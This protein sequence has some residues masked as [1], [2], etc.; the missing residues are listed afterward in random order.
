MYNFFIIQLFFFSV[1]KFFMIEYQSY[2]VQLQFTFSS[3]SVP[4]FL[5]PSPL[6]ASGADIVLS[7]RH[8][9]HILHKDCLGNNFFH[10][11]SSQYWHM[12]VFFC[13]FVFRIRD[14][15]S[16]SQSEQSCLYFLRKEQEALSCSSRRGGA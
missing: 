8:H 13:D 3:T 4:S 7:L 10:L 6:P 15:L 16:N 1:S 2:N 11:S 14:L 5:P 9:F 12:C